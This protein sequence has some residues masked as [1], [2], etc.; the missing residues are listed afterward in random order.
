MAPIHAT[1]ALRLAGVSVAMAILFGAIAYLVESGRVE[2]VAVN[3]ALRAASHY[4]DPARRV[5]GTG[6]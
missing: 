6:D 3:P 2:D 1:I 5:L 4:D